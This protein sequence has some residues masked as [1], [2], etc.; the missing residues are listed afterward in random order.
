MRDRTT[1]YKIIFILSFAATGL[2]ILT[3]GITFSAWAIAG[4]TGNQVATLIINNVGSFADEG[5]G[6]LVNP[7]GY[8]SVLY[9]KGSLNNKKVNLWSIYQTYLSYCHPWTRMKN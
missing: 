7:V 2:V 4:L 5:Q 3:Q 1:V 8:Q 9:L 6:H